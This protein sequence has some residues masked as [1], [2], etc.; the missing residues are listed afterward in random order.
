MKSQ[1]APFLTGGSS[2]GMD[3]D[4]CCD[5][6]MQ[7]MSMKKQPA[8]KMSMAG[9]LKSAQ[10]KKFYANMANKSSKKNNLALPS[11]GSNKLIGK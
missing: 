7:K 3:L 2:S 11:G 4:G 8:G 5:A 1:S 6:P 10:G 9:A